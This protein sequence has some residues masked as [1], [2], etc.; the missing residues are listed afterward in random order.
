MGNVEVVE[1]SVAKV[2]LRANVCLRISPQ[3]HDSNIILVPRICTL[4]P[5][6]PSV[7]RQGPS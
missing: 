1:A 3:F 2:A 5:P 4:Y 6:L 7:S